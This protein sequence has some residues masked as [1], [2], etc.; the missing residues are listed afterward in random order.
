MAYTYDEVNPSLIENTTMRLRLR[1]GAPYQYLIKPNDGYV[2]HDKAWDAYDGGYTEDGEPI[3]NL[4]AGYTIG[5]CS[6]SA[7]YDFAENAREFYAVLASTVPE[8]QNLF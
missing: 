8:N 4:I 7:S 6:C 1:D 3:G 2:L 5:E